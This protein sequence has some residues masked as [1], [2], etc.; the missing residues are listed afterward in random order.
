MQAHADPTDVGEQQ[1]GLIGAAAGGDP[2]PFDPEQGTIGA[3]PQ[4]VHEL[5][6]EAGT[7][8]LAAKLDQAAQPHQTEKGQQQT[9]DGRSQA[10]EGQAPQQ[11]LDQG[12]MARAPAQYI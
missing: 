9:A 5:M 3:Q 12:I 1:V 6:L 8:A 7:E 10:D 2:A 11:A 4:T